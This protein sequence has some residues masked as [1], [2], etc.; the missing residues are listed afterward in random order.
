MFDGAGVDINNGAQTAGKRRLS[1]C[2]AK[3]KKFNLIYVVTDVV[4]NNIYDFPYKM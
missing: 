2:I 3:C 1:I 4:V